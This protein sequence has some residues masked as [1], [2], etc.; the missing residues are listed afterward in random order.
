MW[1]LPYRCLE[2]FPKEGCSLSSVVWNSKEDPLFVRIIVVVDDDVVV[3][4]VV[5]DVDVDLVVDD[6]DVDVDDVAD[7]DVVVAAVRRTQI[8]HH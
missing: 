1:V 6:V 7:V 2:T 4:S 8:F 5:V 3:I